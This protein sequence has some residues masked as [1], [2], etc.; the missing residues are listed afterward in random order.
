MILVILWMFW[1]WRRQQKL[2]AR[3]VDLLQDQDGEGEH[4]P[5]L[6]QYYRPEPF[7]LPDPTISSSSGLAGPETAMASGLRPSIDHR[8]S[9]Y[10]TTTGENGLVLG[11]ASR[12]G[13]PDASSSQWTR[14]SPAPPSFR[15][16]NIVQHEDAGPS[17][18]DVSQTEAETIELPPA[19]TNIRRPVVPETPRDPP[20]PPEASD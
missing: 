6:P 11:S 8:L 12:S 5:T 1:R 4:D 9:Q 13:T 16:V 20:P 18:V 19:Y 2:K 10:S 15:P 17:E 3:P 14:K 7:V